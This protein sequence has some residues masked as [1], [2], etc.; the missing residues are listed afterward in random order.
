MLMMKCPEC[1]KYIHSALLAEIAKIRCEHCAV[2]VPV[3]NVLV[4]ANGFTFERSDLLKRFYRYRKLLDEVM[5]EKAVLENNPKA[6]A[7]SKRS[8]EQFLA[9]LQG[10]MTG[11]REHYRYQFE[12]PISTRLDFGSATCH[13]YFT[14]LSM[15]GACL[16]I[17]RS[18]D[19]PRVGGKVKIEFS[20]PQKEQLFELEGIVCWTQKASAETRE[21]HRLG[22]Q[23]CQLDS[24]LR[25]ILWEFVSTAVT[26][27]P[28]E[29]GT[30]S[31]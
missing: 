13:G 10:M 20:L 23:F 11:A 31:S 14:N 3:N 5:D 9:I 15:E 16:D 27:E 17:P 6:S 2:E 21:R 29:A 12:A 8:L 28:Q 26:Q 30:V 25:S 1:E 18:Q 24:S 7:E 22:V 19:L 4:S